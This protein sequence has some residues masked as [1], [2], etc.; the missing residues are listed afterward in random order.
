MA[1]GYQRQDNTTTGTKAGLG[2]DPTIAPFECS[3]VCTLSAGTVSYKVQYSLDPGDVSDA[4]AIWTDSTGIP[5]G[6][7]ASA[8]TTFYGP[9][10]RVRV[11]IASL[12]GGTL[13][14]QVQQGGSIN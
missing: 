10:S 13:T 4:L 3:V 7:T 5:S 11:V 2:L 6:T 14:T 12:S 9:V 1:L 8:V